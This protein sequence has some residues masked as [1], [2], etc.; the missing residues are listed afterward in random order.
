MPL[1]RSTGFIGQAV[2]VIP[3]QAD[4]DTFGG[5]FE[6]LI[7]LAVRGFAGAD[8]GSRIHNTALLQGWKIGVAGGLTAGVADGYGQ[9][10]TTLV[11]VVGTFFNGTCGDFRHLHCHWARSFPS[12]GIF[13]NFN[14][15]VRL[16]RAWRISLVPQ[17]NFSPQTG[18][19][20]SRPVRSA[21]AV[22]T[23]LPRQSGHS[24]TVLTAIS[25]HPF[26]ELLT[27]PEVV[28]LKSPG[29]RQ[30]FDAIVMAS[31]FSSPCH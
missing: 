13:G 10:A 16:F 8:S 29:C 30:W 21:C 22:H 1:L 20:N 27:F 5:T 6:I 17:G 12:R 4:R 24:M 19:D 28:W 9:G 26:R 3:L 31:L 7:E 2:R 23:I 11:F 25:F 18:Q 14:Y 15:R